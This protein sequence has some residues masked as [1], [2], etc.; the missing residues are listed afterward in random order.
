MEWPYAFLNMVDNSF[1]KRQR[2]IFSG[3]GIDFHQVIAVFAF[4]DCAQTTEDYIW[5]LMKYMNEI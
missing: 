1:S 2:I 3:C 5:P 4:I